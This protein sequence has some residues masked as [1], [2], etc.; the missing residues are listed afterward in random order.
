MNSFSLGPEAWARARAQG[1]AVYML[2]VISGDP[3]LGPWPELKPWTRARAL[4]PWAQAQAVGS[5]SQGPGPGPGPHGL[6]PGAQAWDVG[7]GTRSP[8][9]GLES[10][11]RTGDTF[12]A[13]KACI[14]SSDLC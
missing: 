8:G 12:L 10:G 11:P 2:R 3:G 7:P 4:A 6:G 13:R 14:F 5:A 1:T 9:P